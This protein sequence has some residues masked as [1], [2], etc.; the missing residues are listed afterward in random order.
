MWLYGAQNVLYYRTNIPQPKIIPAS[1]VQIHLKYISI[2]TLSF[3]VH[4]NTH[5]HTDINKGLVQIHPKCVVV[6][7][8]TEA[9]LPKE[10]GKKSLQNV[11]QN[12]MH[13]L[14]SVVTN[15]FCMFCMDLKTILKKA[16]K[17][18]SIIRQRLIGISKRHKASST[19]TYPLRQSLQFTHIMTLLNITKSHFCRSAICATC[20]CCLR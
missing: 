8:R 15:H 9:P 1:S 5:R 7:N 14:F 16:F 3:L 20:Q 18:Y 13:F 11:P 4:Q 12:C 6:A 10:K 2:V 19:R 17:Y